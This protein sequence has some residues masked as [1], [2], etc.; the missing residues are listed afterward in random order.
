MK[1]LFT[2][3]TCISHIG[4]FI[5]LFEQDPVIMNEKREKNGNFLIN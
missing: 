3:P 2:P 5:F 1:S 4:S